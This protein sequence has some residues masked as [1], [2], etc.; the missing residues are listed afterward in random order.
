VAI[1]PSGQFAF[2]ADS[3][4]G[5]VYTYAKGRAGWS[6]VTY[7]STPPVTSFNV[8]A[9]AGPIVIDPSGRLVYVASQRANSISE[10][11]YFGISPYLIESTGQPGGSPFD[12]G[13][14][15]LLMATAL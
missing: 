7:L 1:D 11:Q 14:E 4:K 13:S 8:G 9:G 10:Y 2:E 3:T 15:P 6:L 5:L 12:V